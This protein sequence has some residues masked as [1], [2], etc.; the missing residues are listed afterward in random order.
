M[1]SRLEKFVK[2]L[3]NKSSQKKVASDMDDFWD[4]CIDPTKLTENENKKNNN[5]QNTNR[6]ENSDDYITCKKNLIKNQF[7]QNMN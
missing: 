2:P 7:L 1:S 3:E 4:D 6:D 5:Q